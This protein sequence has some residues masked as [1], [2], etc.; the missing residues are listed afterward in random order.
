MVI[1][2]RP[3]LRTGTRR[4]HQSRY[5][6]TPFNTTCIVTAF[7]STHIA[8]AFNITFNSREW[9]KST[10]LQQD[11]LQQQ[12]QQQ[13]RVARSAARSAS[14]AA[15]AAAAAAATPEARRPM[16]MGGLKWSSGLPATKRSSMRM[17]KLEINGKQKKI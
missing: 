9:R 2:A 15:P 10:R 11:Q 16:T 6:A 5:I 4:F 1:R 17:N 12:Q 13:Q 8:T 7:N 14:E 3:S